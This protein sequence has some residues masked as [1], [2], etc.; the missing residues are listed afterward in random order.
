MRNTDTT[1]TVPATAQHASINGTGLPP[2]CHAELPA[3]NIASGKTPRQAKAS[4]PNTA[5][6]QLNQNKAASG[7]KNHS[8]ARIAKSRSCSTRTPGWKCKPDRQLW[9]HEAGT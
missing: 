3:A 7:A 5:A 9:Y 8:E 1:K 2:G 4:G 6:R